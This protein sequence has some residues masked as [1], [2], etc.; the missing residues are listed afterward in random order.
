MC[1]NNGLCVADWVLW[2]GKGKSF[3]QGKRGKDSSRHKVV[4][5][6]C[7]HELASHRCSSASPHLG[8]IERSSVSMHF[9][10]VGGQSDSVL[11]RD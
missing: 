1:W 9:P 3:L 11:R 4:V 5:L 2:R 8:L 7:S 6:S 10:F